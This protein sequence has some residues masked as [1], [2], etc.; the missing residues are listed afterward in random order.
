MSTIAV[1]GAIS[2]ALCLHFVA[3]FLLQSREMG[4]K[5]SSEFIWLAKHIGIQFSI[6]ALGM[7][8]ML[9]FKMALIFS[10]LNALI[11]GLIDWNIWGLYK[12]SA[13]KRIM[14]EAKQFKIS[15]QERQAW[16]AESGRN[17]QYWEDH[18]FY[19][20]IGFDQLLHS[21]TIVLLL[22]ALL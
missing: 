5:K 15:E 12:L 8:F 2:F 4:K 9:G 21:L 14:Q 10:L 19:A 6:I 3:D 13:Y 11:H 16:V 17:W 18:W 7:S 22:S 20:T 1:I